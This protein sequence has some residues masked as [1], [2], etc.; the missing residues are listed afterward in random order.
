M[1]KT[2]PHKVNKAC[3]PP[4]Y[5]NLGQRIGEIVSKKQVAYGDSFGKSGDVMRIL[6]PYGISHEQMD[7]ALA[8]V[9]IID[10]LFRVANKRN[11]GGES[12]FADIAGYAILGVGRDG[13]PPGDEGVNL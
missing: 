13:M 9:R 12:P 1:K 2:T 4:N 7:D 5:R 10:K 3:W 6:Y 8:V 11:A